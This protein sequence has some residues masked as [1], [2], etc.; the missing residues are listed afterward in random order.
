V[1]NNVQQLAIEELKR[2][3]LAIAGAG[4]TALSIGSSA[5]AEP[6]AGFGGLLALPFG[7]QGAT[8]AVE[9]IR[10]KLIYEPK[11]EQGQQNMQNIGKVLE[12]LAEGLEYV[13]SGAGDFVYDTTGSEELAAAAYTA[14][15]AA[16]DLATLGI[17]SESPDKALCTK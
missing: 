3:G 5:L 11:T 16:L 7:H 12:P 6:V 4:E 1:A 15:T 17:L 10:N 2:R 14:P 8:N 9:N 13:S